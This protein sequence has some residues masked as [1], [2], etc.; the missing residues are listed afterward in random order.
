MKNFPL[1]EVRKITSIKDMFKGSVEMFGDKDAFLVKEKRGGEYKGISYKK[2]YKDMT[3]FG[4][5]LLNMGLAD[6]KIA[7]IGTA[8]YKWSITYLATVNGKSVVVPIDKEL[9]P[10]DIENL[11]NMSGASCV[12]YIDKFSDTMKDIKS[13][14]EGLEYLINMDLDASTDDEKAWVEVLS[15]GQKAVDE[16]STEFEDVEIDVDKMQILL[17]TSGTTGVAKGVM[18]SHKNIA[19]DLMAMCSMFYI[20]PDDVFLSVLPIHHTYECT[21]GFLCP[22]Y[23]GS[24]IAHAEGLKYIQ[25][26]LQESHASIMLG[27]PALYETFYKRIW[28]AAKKS[29]QEPKLKKGLM[30]SNA[31]LKVGIDVRRKLFK[32]VLDNF[33]GNLRAFI[34]G[35]AAINPEV[36]KGFRNLGIHFVQGY[37]I[38]ECSPIVSLN[39]D[40]YYKDEAA[41]L[42]LPC[43][44]VTILDKNSEGIGEI[45]CK[46][47]SV[48]LGYYNNPEAT[49]EAFEGGWFHTGDLGYMDN[50]GFVHITGRKKSV[51][52]TKNGKNIFPEELES[53]I[54]NS[55]YVLESLVYGEDDD[56]SGETILCAL[57]VP[58]FEYIKTVHGEDFSKDDI[59]A[60]IEEV[61]KA[62]NDRNPLYKY[63]RKFEVRETEF[64][65]TTTKKI[66]RFVEIPKK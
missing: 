60:K 7:I 65:K 36:S 23:R 18:L 5:A 45:V 28:A 38:T 56:A 16:G 17:F 66:K 30:I 2:A 51:I 46:G 49:A 61:V 21:C 44:D 54:D 50:D 12:V 43:L 32:S 57:V 47:D 3:A 58:N 27:V 24:S 64:A 14:N 25:K 31:L 35:A 62:V 42:P 9:P 48:M 39:R 20:G 1:Y 55:E 34:S 19:T 22:L 63:I 8:S 10:E 40:K 26:N 52:V 53:L 41:G 6:K 15:E 29:G 13:R 33:G 4:T 37:G 11:I 59:K